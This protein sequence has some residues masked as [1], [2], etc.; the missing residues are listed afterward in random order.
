MDLEYEK[1]LIEIDAEYAIDECKK[2]A[3]SRNLELDYVI[4]EFQKSFNKLAKEI[5]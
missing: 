3:Q 1:T 2:R 5:Q 4:S